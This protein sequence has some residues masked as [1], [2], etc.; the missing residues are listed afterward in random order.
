MAIK[1]SL[2]FPRLF[3]FSKSHKNFTIRVPFSSSHSNS[4]RRWKGL[5][6]SRWDLNLLYLLKFILQK[7]CVELSSA[8][9]YGKSK[10]MN[11]IDDWRGCLMW[12]VTVAELNGMDLAEKFG[13]GVEVASI[14]SEANRKLD[15]ISP[16]T[17]DTSPP[18]ASKGHKF[19]QNGNEVVKLKF[20]LSGINYVLADGSEQLLW[21]RLLT[22]RTTTRT[23]CSRCFVCCLFARILKQVIETRAR[24]KL[25]SARNMPLI[26]KS[27]SFD[28]PLSNRNN[29]GRKSR[30][31]ISLI[32]TRR[33]LSVSIR[34]SLA[35][36]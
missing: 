11:I 20:P 33:P 30:T 23:F 19:N 28:I 5:L 4:E 35:A 31:A 9:R 34:S 13:K 32:E 24:D 27:Q 7:G 2:R 10:S 26:A 22:L 21:H 6:I 17:S 3:D 29:F 1:C 18:P 25:F 16:R 14:I 36:N 8:I 12:L 15:S